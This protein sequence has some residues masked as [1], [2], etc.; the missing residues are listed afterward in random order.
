MDVIIY[1]LP[2]VEYIGKD[3]FPIFHTWN[4]TQDLYN[5][6]CIQVLEECEDLTVLTSLCIFSVVGKQPF[7]HAYSYVE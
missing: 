7:T 3:I 6:K 4:V 5:T 1:Q 2:S